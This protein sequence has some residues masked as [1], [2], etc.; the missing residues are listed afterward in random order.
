MKKAAAKLGAYQT[1]TQAKSFLPKIART[2]LNALKQANVVKNAACGRCTARLG[3]LGCSWSVAYK[4]TNTPHVR[5]H[6]LSV[7]MCERANDT[8]LSGG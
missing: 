5:S 7:P 8:S 3:H 4:W 6:T 1:T 2:A